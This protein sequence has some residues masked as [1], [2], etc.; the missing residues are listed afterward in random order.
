MRLAGSGQQARQ[1]LLLDASG[2][3]GS[4]QPVLVLPRAV[5]RAYLFFQNI[6]PN[7]MAVTFGAAKI[8]P[9]DVTMTGTAPNQ[10]VSSVAITHANT[11]FGYLAPPLVRFEGGGYAGNTAFN[12]VGQPGY[13]APGSIACAVAQVTTGAL[14]GIIMANG[15]GFYGAAPKVF[16]INS[17][18]DPYGCATPAVGSAG[19]QLA[20]GDWFEFNGTSCPT[21][22]IGV[23]ADAAN[24]AFTCWWMT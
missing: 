19:R 18:L 7:N 1:D 24:S 15:G 4:T 5:S 14:S 3:V 10:S 13:P 23:I 16:L 2:T 21:D 17:D 22:Q 9:Q 8:S 12:P 11:G 20:P 6:S